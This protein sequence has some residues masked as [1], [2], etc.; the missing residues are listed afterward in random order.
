MKLFVVLSGFSQAYYP[1][2]C[3]ALVARGPGRAYFIFQGV[4]K[5]LTNSVGF[6]SLTFPLQDTDSSSLDILRQMR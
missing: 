1:W 2:F 3:R 4:V 5:G 6:L